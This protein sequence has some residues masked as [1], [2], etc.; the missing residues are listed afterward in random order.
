MKINKRRQTTS[1]SGNKNLL[2]TLTSRWMP[3]RHLP[4]SCC[5]LPPSCCDLPPSCCHL[6]PSCCHI[7]PFCCHLPH[8]AATFPHPAA[9][10]PHPAAASPHPAATIPHPAAILWQPVWAVVPRP[11]Y[12]HLPNHKFCFP[13][14]CF[15]ISY[16]IPYNQGKTWCTTT[17][18]EASCVVH[19]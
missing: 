10:F 12:G 2:L 4:P 14:R 18:M 1:V 11:P 6:P 8:H 7:P 15:L 17:G 16:M 9:A 13:S 5:H 19:L 3:G